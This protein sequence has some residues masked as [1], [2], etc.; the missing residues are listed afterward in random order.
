MIDR[1]KK[2]NTLRFL[3]N[4]SILLAILPMFFL[5]QLMAQTP[6]IVFE[7]ANQAYASSDYQE[8]INLYQ[9]ILQQ[10]VESGEVFFNLGN[11]YYKQN[12]IGQS[13]LYY[14]KSRKYLEGDPGL[15]QN[16][17]LANLRI[18][19]EIDEIPRLFIE[20]WWY[21]LIHL[22]SM[23]I[24]LWLTFL[25]FST[26]AIF[27]IMHILLDRRALRNFIWISFSIFS[28]LLIL[29]IGHIYEFETSKFGVILEEKVSVVS[30]PDLDGTE[31]F[32]I[33]EGT[34]VRINREREKWL[35]ITIPDGKTGWLKS[36]NLGL[37]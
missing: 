29:T 18:I 26:F 21:E 12:A 19:D 32:I 4:G 3:I 2:V 15:E 13:I 5:G 36:S 6:E 14:E 16:L 1:N 22:F 31:V 28:F 8:A 20:D 25:F 30:E 17:K 27:I 11:A 10:G 34:K 9:K 24:L 23:N 7:S 33:H 37:I 35:E